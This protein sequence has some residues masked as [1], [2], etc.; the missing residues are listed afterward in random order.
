MRYFTHAAARRRVLLIGLVGAILFMVAGFAVGWFWMGHRYPML[1]EPAFK[2]FAVSYNTIMDKYLNGANGED[3]INGASEG[4]VASLEDPYSRYLVEEQGDAYTQG[5]EG[6]FSGIG[7]EVREQDG[8]FIIHALTPNAPAERGGVKSG[9]SIIAVDGKDTKDIKFQD[10]IGL[11]RG[12][13]GTEVTLTLQRLGET[14]P[15]E[16]TLKREAIP[17]YTVTSEMLEEGIGHITIS[18]FAQKTA[19]EFDEAVAKMKEQGMTK[20]LLDLRSNPGGLLQPTIAIGSKLIPKG[21]VILE[22]VYKEE[23]N[24]IVY[25]S[26]QQEEWTIPIVVLVNGQS[27]SA[28]E[29]LTAALKE[30]AGATVVGEKTYGKGVVQAFEQFKDGSV[31]SLTEAQWKTPGGTWIHKV[32]V[33]PNEVVSLPAFA[34]LRPL[35]VGSELKNG[36]YGEDVKTLQSMLKELGY[37][38]VGKDG[39]FDEQTEAAMRAFQKAEKLDVTGSLNDKTAYKIVELLKE[40]LEKEDTQLQRGVE[41]LKK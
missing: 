41:L 38:S 32:G 28:S 15:I 14:E 36:S 10:L 1:K 18:R 37:A 35:P 26:K 6:E 8:Q 20:L 25:K 17:V 23:S 29:V 16:I 31:L 19:T 3:L 7:A 27:A 40:K 39:L 34:S 12:K 21:K 4:M 30:S 13:T 22:V 11:M 2:N 9:D 5:Y 24:P 33:M